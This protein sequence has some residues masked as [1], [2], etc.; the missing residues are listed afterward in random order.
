MKSYVAASLVSLSLIA[1]ASGTKPVASISPVQ[2]PVQQA[3]PETHQ[4]SS[5]SIA[6]ADLEKLLQQLKGDSD[7]FDYNKAVVK[8]EFR[9]VLRKQADFLLAH[10]NDTVT[11]EGNCDERGS[12]AYNLA[13]GNR[14]AFA[15]QH[16]LQ[17]MGVPKQQIKTVSFGKEKLRA[18]CH[19]ESC[20]KVDRRVDFDH[21]MNS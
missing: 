8:P 20:W 6:Q 9:K 19:D 15:V 1:C 21:Q 2:Q 7:Y 14:R 11:L 18:V 16:E 3:Q 4:A 17:H 10:K 5:A 12:D 13:L